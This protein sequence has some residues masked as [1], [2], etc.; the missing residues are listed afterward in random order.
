MKQNSVHVAA[1]VVVN[2]AGEI[3]IARRPP[4]TH[5]GGLWEFPGG[6][7]E[8][9]EAVEVALKREL[10]E[11][12]GITV[13]HAY[14][15]IR[16]PYAYPDKQVLLDVWKVTEFSGEAHGREGQPVKWVQADELSSYKF[17]A[18]NQ[19]IITAARLPDK[20]LITGEYGSLEEACAHLEKR[21]RDGIRL[22]QFRAKYL[23]DDEYRRWA[24]V[25]LALCHKYQALLLL[26]CEVEEASRLGAD[27]I[28]LTSTRLLA[29]KQRPLD[30]E[31]WVAASVHNAKELEWAMHINVDFVVV[32]PVLKTR[33]HPGA[34]PLGWEA[35]Y[36]LTE[37]ASCPVY[38]LGGVSVEDMQQAFRYGAQGIAAIRG[39]A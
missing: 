14:P 35:F 3:L 17:P 10:H 12:T 36:Q 39:L 22:I 33:S 5:Q 7:L 11:E 27:G 24:K 18:A 2:A 31:H 20:Y 38:A 32:S 30:S 13:Q 1:G 19:P 23:P 9:E 15:L 4:N 8:D 25:L 21:L 6:K 34:L 16:I 29:C 37:Q 28:H 26:N